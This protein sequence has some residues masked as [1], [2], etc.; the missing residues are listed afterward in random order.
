MKYRAD[1]LANGQYAVF[2]GKRYFS[3]TLTDIQSEAEI[4]ALEMSGAWYREQAD[5]AHTRLTEL[6]AV[7]STDPYG[8][9]A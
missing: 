9:L 5:A 7:D 6:D 3:T 8:Y 1:Q 2:T 4:R